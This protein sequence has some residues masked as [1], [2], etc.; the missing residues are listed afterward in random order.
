MKYLC[1]FYKQGTEAESEDGI[2]PG[3]SVAG[4]EPGPAMLQPAALLP[5]FLGQGEAVPSLTVR[6]ENGSVLSLSLSCHVPLALPGSSHAEKGSAEAPA[7]LTLSLQAPGLS[8]S[9]HSPSCTWQCR[10]GTRLKAE[11][12]PK[13][14]GALH[15][16]PSPA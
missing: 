5:P 11:P 9:W 4:Q 14:L 3:C 16:S 2:C 12:L 8:L 7:T 13:R 15:P 6:V 10:N 1:P